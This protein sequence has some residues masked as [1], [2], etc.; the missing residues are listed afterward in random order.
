MG[1]SITADQVFTAGQA[2]IFYLKK[3]DYPRKIYLVGTPSLEEE[4]R[5]AG[6]IL[7]EEDPETVVL[8]FDLT[9]TYEKLRS[10]CSFIRQ[11]PVYRHPSRLQL[12][13][14]RGTYS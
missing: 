14:S 11:D 10:A 7:T 3:Y 2:T 13:H 4:F 6:F 9:L 12:P 8:G 1:V 5:Q